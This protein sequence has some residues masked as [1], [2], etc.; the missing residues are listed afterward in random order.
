MAWRAPGR[1][2][3]DPR[4]AGR[5]LSRDK[6]H[7]GQTQKV[8]GRSSGETLSDFTVLKSKQ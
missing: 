2:A 5:R 1:P 3:E 4:Q 7:V 6:D 8:C